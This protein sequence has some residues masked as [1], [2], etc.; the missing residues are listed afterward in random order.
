MT[1][2]RSVGVIAIAFAMLTM[3][4]KIGALQ[5]GHPPS[6]DVTA[7]WQGGHPPSPDVAAAWQ[8]GHPPSPDVFV[9]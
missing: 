1:V 2:K 6:P 3:S 5:G 7:A 8:G 9:S 4:S